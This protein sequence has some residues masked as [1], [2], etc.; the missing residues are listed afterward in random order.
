MKM[1][2][3]GTTLLIR[4]ADS[5]QF[6]VIKSWNKMKWDKATKTLVGVADLELLDKLSDLV[7][8]PP[9]V[10]EYRA[11]LQAVRDAVDRERVK[12][13]PRPF[14]R[15]PV[16]LPLYQ[17]QIRASNM[18]LLTFGWVAPEGGENNG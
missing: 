18:A 6:N 13:D 15:Y 10:E 2:L 17:H 9:T 4:E 3:K 1:A 5:I 8:L 14:Y 7:R 11:R 16:K 12:P